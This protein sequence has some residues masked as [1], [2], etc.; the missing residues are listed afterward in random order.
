MKRVYQAF[1]PLALGLLIL[2]CPPLE[3]DPQGGS[4]PLTFVSVLQTGGAT[5]T[6]DTTG[7]TLTFSEDP[8]SLTV[9]DIT[10]TG[11]TKGVL[12]GS[13]ST[14]SL[15]IS[16]ITVGDGETV[17]VTVTSPSATP[18]ADGTQA[19]VVFRQLSIGMAYKGGVIAY[20]LQSGD[21]GYVSG[22]THGLIAATGDQS[23]AAV[24]TAGG[25]TQT[26]LM[27]GTSTALG[28]GQANTTAILGQAGFSSGAA[29]VADNYTNADTGSGVYS[30][31]YLPSLDELNQLYLNQGTIG[32]FDSDAHYWSSSENDAN[33]AW[34]MYFLNGSQGPVGKAGIDNVRAVRSF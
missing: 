30:D 9:D 4:S 5:G 19:A 17:S 2:G 13:G 26:T 21:P 3:E 7:L 11:A 20:I 31:W 33:N 8:G 18:I 34:G 23:T 6:A 32:G 12:S 16:A 15:T 14:R 29:Q 1:L 10:L 22:E 24:W 25:S 27:G 28:S